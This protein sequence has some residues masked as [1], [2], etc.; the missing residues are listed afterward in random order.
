MGFLAVEMQAAKEGVR[1]GEDLV[2]GGEA[3]SDLRAHMAKVLSPR[4]L[5]VDR[6]FSPMASHCSAPATRSTGTLCRH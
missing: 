4:R 1:D 2:E 3:G 6:S 5:R